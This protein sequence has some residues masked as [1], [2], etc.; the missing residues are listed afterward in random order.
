MHYPD[1]NF[2]YNFY[3]NWNIFQKY[4]EIFGKFTSSL[5]TSHTNEFLK[6][7]EISFIK[8]KNKNYPIIFKKYF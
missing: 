8:N 2:S 6:Y 7:S 5:R 3:M 1:E 4:S